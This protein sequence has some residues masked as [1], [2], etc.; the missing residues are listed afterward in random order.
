[1]MQSLND[2]IPSVI[3]AFHE[4]ASAEQIVYESVEGNGV[5]VL[6]GDVPLIARPG[7]ALPPIAGRAP[8]AGFPEYVALYF[9]FLCTNH[10]GG[11]AAFQRHAGAQWRP[12]AAP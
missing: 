8:G 4:P 1:M 3:R 11:L 12:E 10:A 7:F 6:Q 5:F 2:S 9:F